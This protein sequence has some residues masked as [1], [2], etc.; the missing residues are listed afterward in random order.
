MLFCLRFR[1]G[2]LPGQ[3]IAGDRQFRPRVAQVQGKLFP[4]RRQA[5]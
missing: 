2:F 3:R 5:L 4:L 1:V